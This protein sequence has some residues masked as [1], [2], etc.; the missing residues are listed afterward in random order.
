[1]NPEDI[2]RKLSA[3]A[4]EA[5]FVQSSEEQVGRLLRLL[6]AL[7][8]GGRY[9]ELGTGMGAGLAWLLSTLDAGGEVVTVELEADL[10]EVARAEFGADERVAWVV[11][12]GSAWLR[13]AVGE[14]EGTFDGVFADTWP[15]KYHDRDLAM[16]L[17]KPEGWYL[18]DDLYP[19]PGWPDGHQ[20]S[21]DALVDDLSSLAS[22]NTEFLDLG[23]GVMLC[24]RSGH[25]A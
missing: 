5:G 16:R 6:V 4:D 8:P 17:V 18:V 23:S 12:D 24:I 10:Q 20:T 25:S 9:L 2:A 15:G 19:Q 22:W 14:H 21:V 11:G 3:M 7:R 1:M 13:D